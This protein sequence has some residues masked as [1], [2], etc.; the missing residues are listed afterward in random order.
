LGSG[1]VCTTFSVHLFCS[2]SHNL[3]YNY[4]KELY[5][6]LRNECHVNGIWTVPSSTEIMY[7]MSMPCGFD[8]VQLE[9]GCRLSIDYFFLVGV[10]SVE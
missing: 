1:H 4:S 8:V 10:G 5:F 9:N 6:V 3:F 7:V 2:Y